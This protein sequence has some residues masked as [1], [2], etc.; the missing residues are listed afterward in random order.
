M[1]EIS[2][3]IHQI[4]LIRRFRVRGYWCFHKIDSFIKFRIKLT[5]FKL[6]HITDYSRSLRLFSTSS[7]VVTKQD[8]R[9]THTYMR[10][11][12][13]REGV[14]GG[15]RD[16]HALR[17]ALRTVS[18]ICC[19]HGCMI[20][21]MPAS[22]GSLRSNQK[23]HS[24]HN[25]KELFKFNNKIP[26]V[27]SQLKTVAKLPILALHWHVGTIQSSPAWVYVSLNVSWQCLEQL[28]K[29]RDQCVHMCVCV[30]VWRLC[31]LHRETHVITGL[32]RLQRNVRFHH[33][34]PAQRFH[35]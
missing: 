25:L 28:W 20:Q 30:C 27:F 2:F 21:D 5:R 17:D 3:W 11:W 35:N 33:R 34:Y 23:A 10:A 6:I 32:Q 8:A 19:E 15:E 7:E 22:K 12:R 18:G 1:K 29:C 13:G 4:F 16:E 24:E 14:R 26:A 31:T 9:Q